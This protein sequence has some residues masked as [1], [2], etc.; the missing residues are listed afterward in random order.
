MA[1]VVKLL[2]DGAACAM[3]GDTADSTAAAITTAVVAHVL[4][5]LVMS[6]FP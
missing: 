4:R 6:S 5:I 3:P 1:Y 2:Q